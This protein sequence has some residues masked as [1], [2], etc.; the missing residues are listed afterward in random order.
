MVPA[1]AAHELVL[2]A[3]NCCVVPSTTVAVFGFTVG[4]GVEPPEPEP[5]PEPD[6][7]PEPEP[8]PDPP[9]LALEVTG[10]V[11]VLPHAVAGFFT[12]TVVEVAE[13]R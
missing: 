7:E 2:L 3:V 9:E 6:P 5:D 4:A 8:E 10:T 13:P 12:H 1:T 11:S